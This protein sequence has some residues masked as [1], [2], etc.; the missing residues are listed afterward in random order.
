MSEA[1]AAPSVTEETI[2][3]LMERVQIQC[4]L[5]SPTAVIAMG[6]LDG[7]FYLGAEVGACVSPENFDEQIGRDIAMG[8]LAR[9]VED[10]LWELEG[11]RL[12]CQ[13]RELGLPSPQ[14]PEASQ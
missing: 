3:E 4:G 7:K 2:K 11:Y 5:I 8:K 10:R 9:T 14:G 1:K 13:L 6:F 12:Y